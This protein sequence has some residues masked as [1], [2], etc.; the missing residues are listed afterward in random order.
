[1]VSFFQLYDQLRFQK[2]SRKILPAAVHRPGNL[3]P[4]LLIKHS[5]PWQQPERHDEENEP[6]V[7]I[8][9]LVLLQ[10]GFV[11]LTGLGAV[12]EHKHMAASRGVA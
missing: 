2:V 3:S 4:W 8:D 5:L 11:T 6:A 12:L 10:R 7:N 1:M 9:G